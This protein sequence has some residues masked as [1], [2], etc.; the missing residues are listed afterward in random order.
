MP[1]YVYK[2]LL[3]LLVL[4]LSSLSIELSFVTSVLVL[5]L[6]LTKTLSSHMLTFGTIIIMVTLIGVVSTRWFNYPFYDLLKDFIYFTRPITILFSSYFVIKRIKSINFIFNAIVVIAFLFAIRHI[7]VILVNIGSI[8]SYVYIRTLGGKHN[9]IELVALVFLLFTPYVT[10]FSKYRKTVIFIFFA[11]IILYFSR[12]MF[13]VLFIFYLGHK[14]YLFL[15]RRF[16]KG[17]LVFGIAS[18]IIGISISNVET[19]RNS[20]GLN[21]FIYKTQNSFKELFVSFDVEKV[22]R[23]RRM[24]W[25]HW[26]AYEA[27][28]AI[29]QVNDGGVKAW[30]LGLGFGPQVDLGTTVMLD[31]KM[32][33]KVPSIHNGYI[34]VLFKTGILGLIFYLVFILGIF[35]K[36]QKFKVKEAVIENLIVATSLYLL[37]S[38]FVVT[39]FYRAGE[40]SMFLFGILFASKIKQKSQ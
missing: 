19:S 15:N 30:L 9:H 11:S 29:E 34:F 38:S 36:F 31:G 12:T 35:F 37:F 40:F 27:Q 7:L 26:R 20:T 16:L 23:D 3:V 18:I 32:F 6:C 4:S 5:F 8:D 33:D 39:G 25:E 17:F 1:Q 14:G 28:K 2:T 13:I 22:K 24:L 10:V 21:K